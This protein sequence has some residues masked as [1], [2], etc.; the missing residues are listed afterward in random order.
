MA[1]NKI[2]ICLL[3]LAASGLMLVIKTSGSSRRRRFGMLWLD[4]SAF[5]SK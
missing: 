3:S 5:N 1:S 2:L 4:A